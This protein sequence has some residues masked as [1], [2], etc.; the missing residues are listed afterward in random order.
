MSFRTANSPPD[1]GKASSGAEPVAADLPSRLR[2]L[3]A[4]RDVSG[5]EL[6][7][8]S[9][10]K[11]SFI[12]DII[13]GKSSNPSTVRLVK[14]AQTLGVSVSFLI[15]AEDGKNDRRVFS[16]ATGEED[17]LVEV[18]ALALDGNPQ[19]HGVVT[20]TAASPHCFF[21]AGWLRTRFGADAADLRLWQ[22]TGDHMRPSLL[23]GDTVLVD[24]TQTQPSPPG[25]F[26]VFDGVALV[27]RRLEYLPGS[28]PPAVRLIA[29]N[30]HYATFEHEL[31]ALRVLGR[32]VWF[33][34]EI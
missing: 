5:L 25:M 7:S 31:D 23:P 28:N 29:D 24:I 17:S 33:S 14:V 2:M 6:A 26:L 11:P 19:S 18:A 13:N 34:R 16:A 32:I 8:R 30:P 20:R 27:A 22:M 3:M 9:G 21:R 10:V 15:G 4:E 1:M 12:Y